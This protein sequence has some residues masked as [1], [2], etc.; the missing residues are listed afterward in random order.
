MKRTNPKGEDPGWQ[1][2]TWDEAMEIVGAKFN[3]LMDRYGGQCIFNMAGTSRQW[4]YAV[5]YT[6][7]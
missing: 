4:V 2:I 1:R 7:L 3:E 5:S 6:H